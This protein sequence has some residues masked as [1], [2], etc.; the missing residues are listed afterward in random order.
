MSDSNWSVEEYF[1][2]RDDVQDYLNSDTYKKNSAY[3]RLNS[4]HKKVVSDYANLVYENS[5]LI[6]PMISHDMQE[7]VSDS[8]GRLVSLENR[9]KTIHS[10]RR[11]I[12]AD[13]KDY[14]GSYHRAALNL[15]DSVRYTIIIDDHLYVDK[16]DEYLHNLEAMGYEVI[17]VKNNWGKAVYQGINTRIVAKNK[18]DVFEVQF[19]TPVSY[20]IKEKNTRDL[21]QVI[22]DELAPIELQVRANKLRKLLQTRVVAPENAIEYQFDPDVKR[23]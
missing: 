13:S 17:D 19:H 18:E 6:E 8:E 2:I 12:I 1:K 20:Q 16:V 4:S 22:R 11:K 10:L 5:K 3:Q 14:D 7:L 9:L 15:C 21:Y 23:R